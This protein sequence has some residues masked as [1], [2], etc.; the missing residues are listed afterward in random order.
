MTD[1]EINFISILASEA[2]E[3]YRERK[4]NEL[5]KMAES[6]VEEISDILHRVGYFGNFDDKVVFTAETFDYSTAQVGDYVTQEVVDIAMN[7]LPPASMTSVCAQLGEPYSHRQDPN[8]GKYRP[9]FATFKR[10]TSGPDGIWQYCGH[11]FR[12]ENIERGED[13]VWI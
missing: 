2:A 9:T 11:C 8:T 5:A 1:N 7:V 3:S 12:R 4:C 13:P 10:V 6:W